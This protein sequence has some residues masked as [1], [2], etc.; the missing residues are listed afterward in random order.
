MKWINDKNSRWTD[1]MS[2]Y[3]DGTLDAESHRELEAHLAESGEARRT[4]EELRAVVQAAGELGELQPERDLWAGIAATIEAPGPV[5]DAKVIALPVA[6]PDVE[7]AEDGIRLSRP[8]LI[9]ASVALIAVSSALTAQIGPSW[10]SAPVAD[11]PAETQGAATLVSDNP[12]AVPPPPAIARELAELEST[13]E[14]AQ[15]ILDPNTI[16]VIER[17][18]AVIEQAIADSQEA[19]RLDPGND[20]LSEHLNRVYERKL[21]YLRDAANVAEWS[22]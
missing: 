6:A 7:R 4:L 14:E 15:G 22:S 12:G 5:E 11:V 2:E 1:M 20:Y 17:N 21:T 16:R 19:L 8:Q 18:L 10:G 9:A 3:L 13:L